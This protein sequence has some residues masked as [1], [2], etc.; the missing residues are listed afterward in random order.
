[1]QVEHVVKGCV[2]CCVSIVREGERIVNGVL[3]RI[4]GDIYLH[5]DGC[6]STSVVTE[7]E[8]QPQ[9]QTTLLKN[10]RITN[11]LHTECLYC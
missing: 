4:Q 11:S 6:R 3:I 7:M 9:Q 8:K 10:N 5:Y 1:M 2:S